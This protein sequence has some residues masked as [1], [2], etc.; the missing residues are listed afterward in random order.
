MFLPD[1]EMPHFSSRLFQ[2]V[3]PPPTHQGKEQLPFHFR[4]TQTQI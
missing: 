2:Y 3:L 1:P 4:A